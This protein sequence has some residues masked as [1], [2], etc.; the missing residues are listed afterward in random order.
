V[1]VSFFS[2]I[3]L[4]LLCIIVNREEF[5]TEEHEKTRLVYGLIILAGSFCVI[6]FVGIFADAIQNL[7]VML[8]IALLSMIAIAI[9]IPAIGLPDQKEDE[10]GNLPVQNDEFYNVHFILVLV[11]LFTIIP[12]F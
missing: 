11:V 6:L 10:E 3:S 2:F 8:F 7:R 5:G 4:I 12:S 9:T 1:C